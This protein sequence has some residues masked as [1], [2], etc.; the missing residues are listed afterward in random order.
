MYVFP[1]MLIQ[2][3]EEAGIKVPE[4]PDKYNKE[5]YPHFHALCNVCLCN[6]DITNRDQI[7]YN[8]KIISKI[9]NNKIRTITY[10]EMLD[11]LYL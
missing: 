2:D 11:K 8:T 9:P 4:D 1:S 7:I 6:P 10:G 3:A 5:D